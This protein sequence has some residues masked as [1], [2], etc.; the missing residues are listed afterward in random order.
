MDCHD[1]Y[2]IF[3]QKY[4]SDNSE[5][6]ITL[7]MMFLNLKC[8]P[9]KKNKKHEEKMKINCPFENHQLQNDSNSYSFFS[10][11]YYNELSA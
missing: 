6:G 5:G 9:P 11:I 1:A 7:F 8:G 10:P 4:F 3:K 2:K